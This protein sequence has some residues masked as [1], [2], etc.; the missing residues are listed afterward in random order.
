[1]DCDSADNAKIK[2]LDEQSI[3]EEPGEDHPSTRC[4]QTPGRLGDSTQKLYGCLLFDFTLAI[5]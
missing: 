4:S 1:M 5:T 3:K 2:D